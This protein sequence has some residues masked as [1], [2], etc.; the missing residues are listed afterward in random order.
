VDGPDYWARDQAKTLQRVRPANNGLFVLTNIA[1][2]DRP[3]QNIKHEPKPP[4]AICMKAIR[5]RVCLP[6]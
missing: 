6:P 2:P 1:L 4:A 5:L 3:L